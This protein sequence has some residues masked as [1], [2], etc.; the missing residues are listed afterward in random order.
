MP[1]YTT[2]PLNWSATTTEEFFAF[3]GD[4]GL[5]ITQS[6]GDVSG[7]IRKYDFEDAVLMS[8]PA[9]VINLCIQSTSEID[10]T[11]N[12]ATL[13]YA[14]ISGSGTVVSMGTRFKN[15]Y[16]DFVGEVQDYFGISS[17]ASTTTW[18]VATLSLLFNGTTS[19]AI[20]TRTDATKAITSSGF[21]SLIRNSGTGNN[22]TL[23]VNN[24]AKNFENAHA[25]DI[26]GNKTVSKRK[27]QF[28][29]NDL[30]YF[31]D[32]VSVVFDVNLFD[33]VGETIT[34]GTVDYLNSTGGLG[35]ANGVNS[36]LLSTASTTTIGTFSTEKTITA[37]SLTKTYRAPLVIKIT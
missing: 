18:D 29:A 8:L 6:F 4:G 27:T 25:T 19:S 14:D 12:S 31:V 15:I 22:C 21:E 35:T 11:H 9:S 1:T 7:A 5:T 37:S 28:V 30:I 3:K 17:S 2:N 33:S 16:K 20:Q 10:A 24:L 34:Y 36:A 26:F 23:T 32:G 13:T